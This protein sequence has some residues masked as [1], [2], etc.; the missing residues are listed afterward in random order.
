M[1]GMKVTQDAMKQALDWAYDQVLDGPPGLKSPAEIAEN[2]M[3][4]T[5]GGGHRPPID[6]WGPH[7]PDGPDDVDWAEARQRV[8]EFVAWQCRY[9]GTAGFVTGLGGI[10]ISSSSVSR[11]HGL[12]PLHSAQDDS[13]DSH[14][15][16]L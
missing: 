12:C 15:G 7:G 2:Y 11:P 4:G 14:H 16:W 3:L 10:S 1:A 6:G 9:C 5:M 8:K 13:D